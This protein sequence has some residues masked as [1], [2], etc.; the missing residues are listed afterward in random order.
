MDQILPNSFIQ[1]IAGILAGLSLILAFLSIF[2]NFR[3]HCTRL[4]AIFLVATLACFANHAATYF[5]SLFIIA[6][7]ITELDF[8]QNIAAII[9]GNDAYFS[10]KKESIPEKEIKDSISQE[11][12]SELELLEKDVNSPKIISFPLDTNKLN[13]MQRYV[14]VEKLAFHYLEKRFN[15]PISQHVRFHGGGGSM[16]E[17]D[18]IVE[19][20]NKDTLIEVLIPISPHILVHTFKQKL[21]IFYGAIQYQANKKKRTEVRFVIVTNE[22]V[23][24]TIINELYKMGSK[25]IQTGKFSIEFSIEN[26]TFSEVGFSIQE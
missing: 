11:L 2:Q 10:F 16:T 23:T 8:L 22:K 24:S 5:A 7:A 19:S 1:F 3:L 13:N 20:S 26:F 9:R 6:T 15:Q 12:N 25:V 18:G 14:I 21:S 4:F 17:F